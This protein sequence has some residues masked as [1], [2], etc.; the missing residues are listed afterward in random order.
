ML[1]GFREVPGA[2][3]APRSTGLF[4]VALLLPE[5]AD[6]ARWLAHSIRDKVALSGASDHYVSEALYLRDP[7]YHGIEIYADRPRELWDGHVERM[8]TDPLDVPDLL[9]VLGDPATAD[10]EALPDGTMVGHTHLQVASIP[11]TLAF[12]RDLLEF[13][14][15]ITVPGQ[16][17]FLAAGGYH[18]HLGGNTWNSLG[19]GPPPEGAAAL[20]RATI[21]L[22]DVAERDRLAAKV[23]DAGQEPQVREDGVE[24]RD[25]SGNAIVLSV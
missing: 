3:P 4:H 13:G 20:E 9:G 12:Y 5:R 17:T 8:G 23:A 10:W 11:D 19:A 21:V 24:V 14:E 16:A 25:P 6:L 22:P 15:M 2:Q 1:V 7:D 18:H